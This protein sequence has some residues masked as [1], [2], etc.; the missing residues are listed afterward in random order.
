[1]LC[2]M[3]RPPGWCRLPQPAPAKRG[4]S[5]K[6]ISTACPTALRAARWRCG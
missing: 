4:S 5:S 3:A 2:R 1:L 6:V